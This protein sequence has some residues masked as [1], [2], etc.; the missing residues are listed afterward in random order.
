M[1]L[2]ALRGMTKRFGGLP[3]VDGL[4]LDVEEGRIV[5]LI[6]PNGAGKSTLLSLVAGTIAPTACTSLW[7]A[8]KDLRGLPAHRIR[9]AGIGT[10]PQSPSSFASMTVLEEVAIGA[11]FG[12]CA[13][14][15]RDAAFEQAAATLEL[16]GLDHRAWAPVAGLTL[17]ERR[18]LGLARAVASR[19]RLLLVDEPMAGL[20]PGELDQAVALVR[21]LRDE[22][23]LTVLWVEHVMSAV[24]ALADRVVVMDVGRVI[25]DGQPAQV[26]RD[27][28]VLAAYLGVPAGTP[29]GG[30]RRAPGA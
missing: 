14:L 30:E 24:D 21:R 13:R 4:D 22:Q 27:P 19:P 7:F 8:G 16:V 25:A 1:P 9:R 23:G 10:A 26:R 5:A 12:A 11:R 28:A 20:T 17:H 18:M 3:A 15:G 29:G 2:L 6:G